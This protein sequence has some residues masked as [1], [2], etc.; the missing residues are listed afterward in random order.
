MSALVSTVISIVGSICGSVAG[1]ATEYAVD[2]IAQQFSYLFKHKSKFQNLRCKVGDLKDAGER[3]KQSVREADRNGEVIFPDVER[4]LAA[5]NEKISDEAATQLQEDEEK[6]MKRCFA[7]FCPDFKSRYQLS[8]KAQKE[9]DA[10]AQLLKEKDRFVRVSYRAIGII[11]PVKEYE[12][13]ESRTGAFNGVMVALEDDSVNIIGVYGMGGVGKTTLVKEVARKAKQNQ[14]FDEVVFVAVT[15]TPN[16]LSLQNE[17]AEKLG[18]KFEETSMDTRAARLRERLKKEKKVLIILDD[19]W[20]PLD[21]EALGVPAADEHRGCKTLMTSRR[22]DVLES[23]NSQQNLSI[24]TLKEDE[25]WDLFKNMAGHIV[26]RSDLQSIAVKVAKRCAGLPIAIATIAKALKH[27]QNSFEWRNAL[28]QLSKPSERS[29]KG[30]PADAYSAIEL[31]Y[32][33]LE[34]D[35]LQPIFLLCSIMGHDAAI[36]DLLRYARGLGLILDVNRM[37]EARDKVLTLVSNLKASCL[38]LDG[39]HPT[40]FDMHDVVRDVALSIASRDHGWLA[41]GNEDVVAEWSD[42]DTVRNCKLM[43][44][45]N[46]EVSELLN[47]E[48]EYPNLAFFSMSSSS[49]K[50]PNN[51]FEGMKKLKVLSFAEMHLSS[52]PSS[53]SSL[54]NLSALHLIGCVLENIVILGEL[55]NLEILDLRRSRIKMLPQEIGQLNRLKLLDLSDC[56]DLKVISPNVLSSLSR[57]EELYLYGSFEEWEVEGIDNP[58]SKASLVELQHL[59]RLTTLEV[60]INDKQAMPKDNLFF[61]KLERYKISIGCMWGSAMQ[62]SRMLMLEKIK[63]NLYHGIKLLLRKTEN[64]WLEDVED[65]REM[66]YD[67]INQGFPE[68][69]LLYVTGVADIK[70]AINSMMLVSCLESLSLRNFSHLEAICDDHLKGETF[71]RLRR[72]KVDKCEML[73]NLFSFSIAT[74]FCQLEEIHVS[75]C[76]NMSGLIVDKEE[77]GVLEFRRLH[78]L[79]LQN[80]NR[81]NGLW[82][83]EST[84][85]FTRWLFDKKVSCPVLEKL[86]LDS[87]NGIEKIWHDDQLSPTMSFGVGTLTSLKIMQCHKLK[88]VFTRSMVKSFVQLKELFVE[89]CYG[90]KDIIQGILG[91]ERI[92]SRIRLF[93]KLDRL[94]LRDLPKLK[95]FCSGINISIEFPSLKELKIETCPGLKTFFY[96][97]TNMSSGGIN[98]V[99]LF[100][101]KMILP[102]LE[103]LEIQNVDNVERLWP[104]QLAQHSF[105]KL[106]YITLYGCPKL[107]NV[108]PWSML[109]RLERL[110]QLNIKNCKSVEEIVFESHEEDKGGS[111]MHSL[112]PQLIQS[113]AVTFEFPR[114][115]FLSLSRLPNL[116]SIHHEMHAINWPSLK[117]ISVDGCDKVKILFASQETNGITIQQPLFWVNQFTFPNL[118]RLDLDW[119][120]IWHGQQLVS[121]YFPNL[122]VVKLWGY[123]DQVTVLPSYLFHFLSLSNVQTLEISYCHFKEMIPQTEEEVGVGGKERPARVVL[124]RITELHLLCLY[125]LMHL[126]KE[127][128]AFQ[129]LKIL[130][131]CFCPKLKINLVPS[132]VSFRNLVTLHVWRCHRIIKLI[133]HSTAKSLVQLKEMKIERCNNIEEIIQGVDGDD[134]EISFPQL[135]ILKLTRLQ[136]LESFCSAG[137]YT[138]GFPSLQSVVVEYCPEMKMFSQGHSDTPMLHKVLL[139]EEG[140]KERWEGSLNSTIQRLFQ[141]KNATK[142]S[143]NSE[144]DG[145]DPFEFDILDLLQVL[146]EDDDGSSM[147]NTRLAG[148]SS[149]VRLRFQ[150]KQSISWWSPPL[151]GCMELRSALILGPHGVMETSM[152]VFL[153]TEWSNKVC[154]V[155]EINL[156]ITIRWTI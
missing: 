51:F 85:Q 91:E 124:S 32:K 121:H 148:P 118:H 78:S 23:M 138:F 43:N 58:R 99:Q 115:T 12:V 26:E 84:F 9:A 101:E 73:K 117:K 76:Y 92:K 41:F 15:Q 11:R 61:G 40:R 96:D 128:E 98:I 8:K 131:V 156:V 38:L 103:E 151:Q 55:K 113:D 14:L 4:W 143:E 72:L 147:S 67:P 116:K 105:S 13:F 154:L 79:T 94:L 81:F 152:E 36:E 5:V 82:Y 46:A 122:K 127:N 110:K 28:R 129:N 89:K 133:T 27:K 95:R 48:F 2:P 137:I 33:F 50:I 62:T 145:S 7:G 109:A 39:S 70:V 29:F 16:L 52:L 132:S 155:I 71:G 150:V 134:D 119:K 20:V 49:L 142:E 69:K 130:E 64:L 47:R 123:P 6:A 100:N 146:L 18:M 45:Q 114:L 149:E 60:H 53:I 37:E 153:Q 104:H 74:R 80:L 44:L 10:I 65:V 93:P 120:E 90:V 77:N 34:V 126:W 24:E 59:S 30:I 25:A 97:A 108:F 83:S 144:D 54:K 87:V 106:T 68:L 57:L 19:I 42:G 3:V 75:G 107:L 140:N 66:L 112:S 21:L 125:Q 56:Y 88:Y 17:I 135:N 141:K 22:L 31:S 102:V 86:H 1:K 111:V 139:D 63:I 35:E 136:K